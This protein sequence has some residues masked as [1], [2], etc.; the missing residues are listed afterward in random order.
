MTAGERKR[1]VDVHEK[2]APRKKKKWTMRLLERSSRRPAVSEAR[3]SPAEP[4]PTPRSSAFP[5]RGRKSARLRKNS[6]FPYTIPFR[7]GQ[8]KKKSL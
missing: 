2:I 1:R 4:R 8:Q 7:L 6:E 5:P 3:V